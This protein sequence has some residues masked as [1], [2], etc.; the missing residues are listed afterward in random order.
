M[1]QLVTVL[2]AAALVLASA[3]AAFAGDAKGTIKSINGNT[4]TV[5]IDTTA[6]Y[7]PQNVDMTGL[8]TGMVVSVTFADANNRH[9]VSKVVK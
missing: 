1:K 4:R 2:A 6:Y 3:G 5:T 8:T 7:F 9:E